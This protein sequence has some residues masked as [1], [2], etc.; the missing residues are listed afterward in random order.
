MG[1]GGLIHLNVAQFANEEN[2][3]SRPGKNKP[4]HIENILMQLESCIAKIM[5]IT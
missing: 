1:V 2:T 4:E 3:F 5:M